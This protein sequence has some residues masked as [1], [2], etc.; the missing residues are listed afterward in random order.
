[1][2]DRDPT[3]ASLLVDW[4]EI[5]KNLHPGIPLLCVS[6]AQGIGKS[7]ALEAVA[8]TYQGRVVTL[9]IDDFYL[10]RS[11]REA[12]ATTLSPLFAVRGPPGTHD[13][14]LLNAVIDALLTATDAD[15]TRLP[16]FDKR[17]DDRLGEDKWSV[18]VGRPEAIILEGWCIGALPDANPAAAARLNAI[19]ARADADAWRTYQNAQLNGPYA[20]LWDRAD[21]FLHLCAP[22]FERVLGWRS[23]QEE[24]TLGL[25]PGTLPD[26][27]RAWVETFIQ[28]YERITRSLLRGQR[29]RGHFIQVAADRSVQGD[30][31]SAPELLVFSDLDGTLLDHETYSY[32]PAHPA[33]EA[34]QTGNAVL[35]L[36]SS[37]TAAEIDQLRTEIGFAHCPAIVENGGGILEP[38]QRPAEL[39]EP[40]HTAILAALADAPSDL[41]QSF[42]GFSDWRAE[43]VSDRTGLTLP[44]A[45]LAK[46]R[47]YSEPGLWT[48]SEQD[49]AAFK[50][51]LAGFGIFA[52]RGGR[53]L[54]LSHGKTKA[55]QMFAIASRFQPAPMIALG[56]APNDLEMIEAAHRGVIIMNANGP[57]IERTSGEAIGKTVRSPHSGPAGWNH[58]ILEF[59]DRVVT[60]QA[61]Q[62]KQ[63]GG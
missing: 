48:G 46:Q 16:V 33:L 20:D 6:G 59:I 55:D 9:G 23:E 42:S 51:F 27:R 17:I 15:E 2:A 30:L 45:K 39:S 40:P 41:R 32:A 35:V 10:T 58:A 63:N 38:N 22:S 21:A 61:S 47:Q 1:M 28:H 19:E 36:S 34:L 11:E 50:A 8:E 14:P 62:R 26:D 31:L 54:T 44:A 24:T 3:V 25:A 18:F 49:L 56:D 12:L 13:L 53:F 37:K 7:T 29:R 4:I 57:K 60:M 5:Q 43:E 52:Q